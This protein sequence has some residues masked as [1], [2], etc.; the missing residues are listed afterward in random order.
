MIPQPD[1]DVVRDFFIEVTEVCRRLKVDSHEICY[2]LLNA[3]GATCAS[4]GCDFH[5]CLEEFTRCF[6]QPVTE[7]NT[8]FATLGT[9]RERRMSQFK[10]LK[11]LMT[12]IEKG[13]KPPPLPPAEEFRRV[14]LLIGGCINWMVNLCPE[15][16]RELRT[17]I[18]KASSIDALGPGIARI[19]TKAR[20]TNPGLVN[21]LERLIEREKVLSEA[22]S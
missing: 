19:K 6:F 12:A 1:D 15:E 22:A 21:S 16:E 2:L 5:A 17:M 14:R 10:S 4:N 7:G 8:L 20:L 11:E 9:P 3:A 18:A 13:W